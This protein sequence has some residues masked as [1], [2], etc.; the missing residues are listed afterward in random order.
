MAVIPRDEADGVLDALVTAGYTATYND[1]RGGV[2]RQAQ[3]TLLIAVERAKL[4]QVLDIVRHT[5]R[6]RLH[7]DADA[8]AAEGMAEESAFEPT[9]AAPG[10]G[11]A[12]VFVWD[13]EQFAKY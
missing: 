8:P 12:V 9:E 3:R 11:G 7:L 13:L 4:E 1:S 10:L 2:L 6:C 5:C